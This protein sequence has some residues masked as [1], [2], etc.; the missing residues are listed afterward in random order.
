M[1]SDPTQTQR[2]VGPAIVSELTAAGFDDAEEIGRGGFGIVYRCTQV[3]LDRTVAV[4]VLTADLEENRERFLRE[5]RAM[6][7]LTG[8]PNIVG[9][10]QVGE[11][12]SGYP[13]L[14]MQY[15]RRGS[16][17]ARI[18]RVGP[19]PLDEV[20][21][22][23]VKMAGAL[24]TAH[25]VG[26][27]HRDIKPANILYTDYGEPALTDFGIAH[28][29]GGFKTATGTFTGSPAFTAPE[30]LSGDPPTQASDVYGLGAT[31]FCALTG[32]AA[33]ERRSGEQVVAQFLRI[34]TES[35]PDL[36]ESGISDDVAAAIEAAMS[37]DPQD[38][39][40]PLELGEQLR[41]LQSRHGFPVDEMATRTETEPEHPQRR[42]TA[43]VRARR[44][45]S[46]I[47]LE[48][49]SFIGRRDELAEVKNLLTTSRLVTLTGIGGVGKTRLAL[50]AATEVAAE[51]PDGVRLVELGELRDASSLM[52][53]VAAGLD[54]RDEPAKP[55]EEVLIDFLCTR[56]LLLV[57]DN[58]EHVVDAAAKLA[59]TLLRACPDLRILAT[60]REALGI[61]GETVLRLSPL[62]F[63]DVDPEP[64][65]GGLPG[66]D[67]VALFAERAAAAVPGFH[68]TEDNK[69]T[70]AQICSRLDGLPLAIELAA[71]R[72]RVMSPAQLLDRLADRYAVLTRGS[73]GAPARQQTLAWSV[74][75]SYDLCTPAEQQL[76]VRLSVFAGSF[77]LE[78]AEDICGGDLAPEDVDDL[79]TALVDKSI[80]IRTE[81]LDVVRFRL[82]ETLRD[83]GREKLKTTSEYPELRRRHLDWYQRLTRD[84]ADEWFSARQ[85]EWIERLDQ[86][87]PNLREA[88]EY[89]LTQSPEVAPRVA[90]NLSP[91]WISHGL[92]GEG[93]R[94]LDQ[95]LARTPPEPTYERLEAIYY[96][97]VLASLQGD[98]QEAAARARE[99]QEVADRMTGQLADPQAHALV[100]I[101]DGFAA[102]LGGDADR[103][104]RRLGEAVDACGDLTVRAS[105]LLLLA[106]AHEMR[107]D[108]T[109]ALSWNRRVC[110]LAE[111]HGESVYRTWAL[112]GIGLETWLEGDGEHAANTFNEGLRLAQ[113]L[114]DR[115]TAATYLEALAW[116]AADE[117][118][119]ERAVVLM[120]AAQAVGR[121]VGNYVFLFPNLP[122]FH[123]E[124]E[125]RAREALD[126]QAYEAA[127][128]VGR[129]LG[130]RDAVAYALEE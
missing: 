94:W 96:A 115:R 74:G 84:A 46:N 75:W 33:Y 65:L 98:V 27:L 63:P 76:W 55:L 32:H 93:R 30:I 11:T 70:V 81:S 36:R 113:R 51:F 25:G 101:A 48:L 83:Y 80:L 103:A 56:H 9:V 117:G 24:A 45:L 127:N 29:T 107:G 53:V 10:L 37:R 118:R 88:V 12:A 91:F 102:M 8:H 90:T 110:E 120:G 92:V 20:L 111:S 86:E 106:R 112:V 129:S 2:D 124:C 39:P 42:A 85:I 100:A 28:I 104:C 125:R 13:Y 7:R 18:R 44:T 64:T 59:E 78:A 68:L 119:A 89:S 16:L 105:A 66:F 57:L 5:Q 3:D 14:V 34:A 60:S 50:R 61:G 22:L 21:R 69:A 4:K 114:D 77:E 130:L 19:L 15:H 52:D 62:A 109:E 1:K 71:A 87:M 121:G 128:E 40:S 17:E 31:L 72:L 54:L 41:R 126:A 47:P 79:L 116:L 43:S 73:R 122:A 23:G 49:T 35:A 82:L 58:C 99:A 6:G 38:R 26:I 108:V 97:S 95:A 123:E 67:A